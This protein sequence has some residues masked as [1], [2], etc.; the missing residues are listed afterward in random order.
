VDQEQL[1]RRWWETVY[2]FARAVTAGKGEAVAALS[3]P[4]SEVDLTYRIFGLAPL[5]FLMKGHLQRA[6][7]TASRAAWN[8][9]TGRDVRIEVSWIDEQGRPAT[10]GKVTFHLEWM[11][12]GWRVAQ[13]RPVGLGAQLSVDD[14]RE[15]FEAR[16]GDRYAIGLLAGTVQVKCD[17]PEALDRVE[18]C[19]VAGMQE[20]RFGL[21]EIVAAVRLWRDFRAQAQPTYRKPQ[22]YAAAVEYIVRL[23]GFYE[24]S[25][26]QAG[27]DYG[28]SERT[29]SRHYREI[30]DELNIVQFDPRYSLIQDPMSDPAATQ[31]QAGEDGPPAIPLGFGRNQS[32]S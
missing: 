14:A 30:R 18:D 22:G 21:P 11:Q 7:L 27:E 23:L 29:V 5:V 3:V 31:A 24:G 28:V 13:I 6:T 16:R 15:M 1:M 19:L 9:E 2:D 12:P 17:G 20:H 25:Q 10:D 32:H 8:K 4:E 26:V